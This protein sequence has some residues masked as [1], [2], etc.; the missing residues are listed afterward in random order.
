VT[1][2]RR[3]ARGEATQGRANRGR[4]NRGRQLHGLARRVLDVAAVLGLACV[5]AVAAA[6]LTGWRPVVLVSGSMAPAMP[7][8]TLVVTRPVHPDDLRAGDVVTVP[9]PGTDS[10][11]THRVVDVDRATAPPTATLRGDANDA[12]DPHAYPLT[13]PVRRAVLHVPHVGRAV[14]GAPAV[15]LGAGAAA[16]VVLALLPTRRAPAD[17]G[18]AHRTGAADRGG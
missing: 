14:Q 17:P 11:V 4:A 2:A 15:V 6:L 3:A 7:A 13:D 16:L 12:D 1:H 18:P 5:L 8:G 10:L 9:L